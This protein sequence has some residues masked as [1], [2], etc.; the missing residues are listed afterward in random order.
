MGFVIP[1]AVDDNNIFIDLILKFDSRYRTIEREFI[2]KWIIWVER[3]ERHSDSLLLNEIFQ[4]WNECRA[5]L[6]SLN[7]QMGMSNYDDDAITIFDMKEL[8]S[9]FYLLL[10]L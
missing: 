3:N 4:F 10:C 1:F 8:Q 6:N 9:S 2:R 5:L 7:W